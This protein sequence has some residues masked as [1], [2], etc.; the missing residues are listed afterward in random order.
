MVRKEV[1]V[2]EAKKHLS[3]L[4]SRVAYRGERITIS[5]RGKPMAILIPATEAP[6]EE[7][8]GKVKGWL[9]PDDPFFKVIGQ[10]VSDRSKHHPRVFEEG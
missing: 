9:E 8:V 4:L 10:I 5:K 3:D 6:E 1:S 7:H 2:A